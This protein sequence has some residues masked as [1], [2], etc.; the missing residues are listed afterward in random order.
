MLRYLDPDGFQKSTDVVVECSTRGRHFPVL[1]HATTHMMG[2]VG[3]PWY[4]LA[5]DVKTLTL[6]LGR[7][8]QRQRRPIVAYSFLTWMMSA[9]HHS[10]SREHAGWGV[11]SMGQNR[12]GPTQRVRWI[13]ARVGG[14]VG[15]CL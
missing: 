9:H 6:V 1:V 15:D 4:T 13:A 8:S 10:H 11:C 2:Y 14:T 3:F 7:C 12:V 5:G